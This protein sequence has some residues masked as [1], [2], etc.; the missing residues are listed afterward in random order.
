MSDFLP[1]SS[2]SMR[3]SV[4]LSKTADLTLQQVHLKDIVAAPYL[5]AQVLRLPRH[6]VGHLPAARGQVEDGG[7]GHVGGLHVVAVV[8][9]ALAAGAAGAAAPAAASRAPSSATTATAQAAATAAGGVG[10]G[11]AAGRAGVLAVTFGCG[12]IREIQHE[13]KKQKFFQKYEQK[14]QIDTSGLK[15]RVEAQNLLVQHITD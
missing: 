14:R 8:E 3:G 10:A 5:R 2:T 9:A 1:S 7:G 6:V 12:C 11:G 13:K 15:Q 4:R